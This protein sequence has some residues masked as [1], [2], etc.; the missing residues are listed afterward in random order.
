MSSVSHTKE[1]KTKKG[2]STVTRIGFLDWDEVHL[3]LCP[4]VSVRA[5]MKEKENESFGNTGMPPCHAN[6]AYE[7]EKEKKEQ[8]AV[9]HLSPIHIPVCAAASLLTCRTSAAQLDSLPQLRISSVWP[10][11]L[12]R[13]LG[14]GLTGT[15]GN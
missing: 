5:H 9:F 7:K 12:E 8:W 15:G 6:G 2:C 10:L 3:C 13:C 14:S 11:S 1:E 4:I